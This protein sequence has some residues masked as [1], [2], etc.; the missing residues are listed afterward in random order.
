M[1]DNISKWIKERNEVITDD[2]RLR[3]HCKHR[4]TSQPLLMEKC[5]TKEAMSDARPESDTE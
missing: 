3:K 1:N 4:R 5:A 2:F